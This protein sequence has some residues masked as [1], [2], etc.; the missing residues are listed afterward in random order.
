MSPPSIGGGVGCQSGGGEHKCTADYYEISVRNEMV[1]H[2]R[3]CNRV[4]VEPPPRYGLDAMLTPGERLLLRRALDEI[5]AARRERA[6]R[7][8]PDLA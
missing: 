1:A 4:V 3:G 2:C 5:I 7:V 8:T 6:N